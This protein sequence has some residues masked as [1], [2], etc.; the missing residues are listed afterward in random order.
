[1]EVLDHATRASRTI[2]EGLERMARYY[3][4]LVERI[5]TKLETVGD[6]ARITHRAEPPLVS[7]RHAVEM[8]FAAIIARGRALTQRDWP[9]RLVR[10]VHPRPAEMAELERFFGAPIDF[11]QPA[12]E[13]IFDRR[14]LDQP[15]LTADPTLTVVLDRYADTLLARL[16]GPDP[17][18]SDVR[19]AVAETL[20][21]GAPSLCQTARRLATS[22]RTLQRRLAKTG[23]SY[24]LLVEEVRRELAERYLAERHLGLSEVA[25][26]LGFSEGSAFHRAF[27]RWTG[28]TPKQHRDALIG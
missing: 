10:F 12:D 11:D 14:F 1:M 19:R 26:L 18:L 23:A 2:G 25:Y 6:V 3:R 17:F 5:E 15:L 28:K 20:R 16:S 27:R 21:G 7:P 9:L 13:I 8:L 4:L 22:A 24:E